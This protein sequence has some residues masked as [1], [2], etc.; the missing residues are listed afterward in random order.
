MSVVYALLVGL[1]VGIG[2]GYG[3][4][5]WITNKKVQGSQALQAAVQTA[6]K[7]L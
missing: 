7:K 1:T 2:T 4:R 3:F 5:G 6:A